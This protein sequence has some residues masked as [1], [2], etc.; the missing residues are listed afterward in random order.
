MAGIE[1]WGVTD[2]GFYRPTIEDIVAER[3]KKAKEIFGDDFDTSSQTP[4]GKYFRVNAAAESKLCEIVEGVYYSAY[5][6]T[7]TGVSLDRVCS[8][9]NL[10]REEAGEAAH[11]IRVYGTQGHI[12]EGGTLFKNV[13]GIEFY[14]SEEAVINTADGDEYYADIIVYCTESGTVGNV[15]NINSTVEVDTNISRIEY[16]KTVTY[17]TDIESDPDLRDKYDVVVQ[18]LGTN[19][20]A[21]IKANVLRVAGVNDVFI[22]DNNTT[23]AKT[24]TPSDDSV[25]PL[26]IAA[27]SYAVIVY[28]DDTSNTAEIAEAIRQKEPLGIVQSGN[29]EVTTVDDSN[30]EKVVKFTFVSPVSL[31]INVT[32]KVDD[33]FEDGGIDSIKD[34]ITKYINGLGIGEEVVYS[35]LYNYI[36]DV[37]GVYKITNMSLNGGINDIALSRIEVAKVGNISVTVTED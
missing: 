28:T 30:T 21:A 6:N 27:K 5:P 4:Q 11:L 33:T 17:G 36:Y 31:D 14:N 7:A 26:T 1:L 35:Q 8:G 37:T 13:A 23:A 25:T 9:V 20:D 2:T 24:I 34:S 18:G 32:C 16:I 22:I 12:K 15:Q 3:N 10:D 19:T 29:V